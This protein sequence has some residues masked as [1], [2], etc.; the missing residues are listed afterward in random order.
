[1]K[2]FFDG[3]LPRGMKLPEIVEG[4]EET[5]LPI[6]VGLTHADENYSGLIRKALRGIAEVEIRVMTMQVHEELGSNPVVSI[7]IEVLP[8][9]G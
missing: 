1:M 5:T 6:S 4:V 2:E 7:E 3:P 9:E 8:K